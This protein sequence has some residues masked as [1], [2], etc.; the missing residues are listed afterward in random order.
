MNEETGQ[1]PAA[2]GSDRTSAVLAESFARF[3][4]AARAESTVGAAR[5]VGERAVIP[6]GEVWY[7]GGLGLGS[8]RGSGGQGQGSGTGGG[9]GFGG[10][11][12]PVAVVDVG[13]EGVR[14]RPVVD[15]TSLG[16]ALIGV[17][18]AIVPRLWRARDA[19][20]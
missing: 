1:E 15:V 16:L 12:R 3:D 18:M 5:H 4:A 20:R 9:G 7:G 2:E 17:A 19:R 10:R 13:P 11:V 14:V 8:G 6:L